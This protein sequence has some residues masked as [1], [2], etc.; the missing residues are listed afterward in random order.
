MRNLGRPE[1]TRGL[2]AA[3][4]E[5]SR[6]I[7]RNPRARPLPRRVPI[8]TS[9]GPTGSGSKRAGIGSAHGPA[10]PVIVGVFYGRPPIFRVGC[11][12]VQAAGVE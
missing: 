3:L 5:A 9:P 12:V 10:T 8:P 6:R 11:E 1:A 7:E 2:I 4:E